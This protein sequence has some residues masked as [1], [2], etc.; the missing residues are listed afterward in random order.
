MADDLGYTDLAC[1]GSKYYE[2]PNI[3]RLAQQGMKL[4]SHHH[5]Q[6][7]TP[8]RAALM[9]GQVGARTGVYTVGGIDRFDW[10]RRPLRPVDNVTQLPLDRATIAQQLKQAGYATGMF[11]KWHIGQ[12][13]PYHPARRG[14]DEAIVSMGAHFDFKTNPKTDYPQGQYLADFLTDRA[15]DFLKRHKDHPFFLYLPHF[16]VHAPLDAKPELVAKFKQ[17]PGVGGH[18]NPTYAAM[19][20]S[21]DESVGRVMQT[22]DELQLADRTLLI[23]TSDNGGVGGYVR[24]GLKKAGDTTDNAPLRSGKG[25]LYEGGTRVPLI[26]RWPGVTK[27]GSTCDIPSI[28]VDLFPTLLEISGAPQP[29]QPLDGESLAPLWRD[30]SAR[31]KRDA[32]FQHF[33]GY[34]GAGR[35][36]WRTTPVSLIQTGDWKLMEFLEDGHLELYNLRDDIGE[37]KN[38]AAAM[39]ERAEALRVRLAAWR[40]EVNA[41]MPT[42][43][44]AAATTTP[45]RPSKVSVDEPGFS[46]RGAAGVKMIMHRRGAGD[47]GES[48]WYHATSTRGGFSVSLPNVFNDFTMTA[49]AEDGV[50]IET[51]VIGTRD[52][53]LV[54]FTAV[55]MRRS[56]GKFKVDPLESIME[57]S[58]KQGELKEK[59][60]ISLGKTKGIELRVANRSSTAVFRIYK[61]R[62]TVYQLIVEAPSSLP[63]KE[64]DDDA[65]RFMDSFT[66][67]DNEQ[68]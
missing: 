18:N 53:R 41:P 17:K 42:K 27:P 20:A 8:T 35:D 28:H 19:I 2:T 4:L 58:T 31:L 62:T 45:K 7:C 12:N 61:A 29:D 46:Q 9:S 25:S 68:Q 57:G 59:R 3:D 64:I 15:V 47:L 56:D 63:P 39:P 37:S 33:P 48:G 51:F 43:N 52:E 49:K 66:I 21:V 5:C 34:L 50:D 22:L 40:T 60:P 23:F 14:F 1:F 26:V 38:L 13:G 10:S 11:G 32:I 65:K 36:R 55:A 67:P 54:K 30:G 44:I 6:N 16:A 24:E